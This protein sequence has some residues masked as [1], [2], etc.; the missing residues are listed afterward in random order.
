MSFREKVRRSFVK[1]ITYRLLIVVTDSIIIFAITRR[2]DTTIGVIIFS[3]LV[4]TV[5]YF[6]HERAWA[7]IH[8]GK[9]KLETVKNKVYGKNPL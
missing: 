9:Y 2:F 4:S 8:W 1:A 3:N 6:L 7:R 5:M